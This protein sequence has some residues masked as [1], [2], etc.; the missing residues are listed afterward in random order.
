MTPADPQFDAR[1]RANFAK[2]VIMSKLRVSLADVAPGRVVLE[3]PFQDD[4]IQQHGFIHAGI[5]TTALD[6][7]CGYAAF[8]LMP[9]EAEVLTVEF[10]SN[11][12]RPAAGDSFRFEGRVM[13]PGKTLIITEGRAF[14]ITDQGEKEISAMQ[15][16]MMVVTGREGIN[17]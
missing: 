8:S 15:A 5:I 3:M 10:K 6:S 13:K 2:Q 12:L 7:A 1:V 16:T 17:G 14:A 9:A 11:F 4:L